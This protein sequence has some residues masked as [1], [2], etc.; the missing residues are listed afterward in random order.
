MGTRQQ[1]NTTCVPRTGV[2]SLRILI[3]LSIVPGSAGTAE[4]VAMQFI[5]VVNT[6]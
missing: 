1:P 4:L 3:G 6:R 5:D 2:K